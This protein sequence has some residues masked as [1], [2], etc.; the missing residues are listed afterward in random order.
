MLLNPEHGWCDFTLGNF[1]G[2]P[3]YLTNVPLDTLNAFIDYYQTGVGIAFYDE[4]GTEF[5]LVLSN[6]S[7]YIISVKDVDELYSFPDITTDSLAVELVSDIENNLEGWEGFYPFDA[8]IVDDCIAEVKEKLRIL[9]GYIL[10]NYLDG[11]I[12]RIKRK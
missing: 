9:K 10:K 6:Y 3:S 7:V 2:T 8:D 12:G 4:E 5:N 11:D 1:K